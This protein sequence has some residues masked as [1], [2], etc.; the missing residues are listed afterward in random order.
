MAGDG[1]RLAIDVIVPLYNEEASVAEF[2]RQ[3]M[4]VVTPLRRECDVRI[5]YVD[6]G[7]V[8]GTAAELA[9]LSGRDQQEAAGHQPEE[10]APEQDL[11]GLQTL[12]REL[13]Q[14]G[15]DDEQPCRENH[16]DDSGPM[17]LCGRHGG[18]IKRSP[19]AGSG[20]SGR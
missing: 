12:R 2:H 17:R 7:S 1:R 6:D 13:H 19:P 14:A 16:R 8:D 15:A 4:A 18:A 10:T 9:K 20:Q 3:L 11:E 5:C